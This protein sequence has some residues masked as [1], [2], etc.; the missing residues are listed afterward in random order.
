MLILS[1]YYSLYH[2]PTAIPEYSPINYYTSALPHPHFH[3]FFPGL[4]F[5]HRY[6]P[7]ALLSLAHYFGYLTYEHPLQEEYGPRLVAPTAEIKDMFIEA[8][9]YNLPEIYQQEANVLVATGM[10][11]A[12]AVTECYNRYN[13]KTPHM[14]A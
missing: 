7:A 6:G 13:S 5:S 9:L 11:R 1:L 12:T 8:V 10:S 3:G 14:I 4:I 2:L